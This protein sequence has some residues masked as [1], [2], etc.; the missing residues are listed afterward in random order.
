MADDIL[1]RL[2]VPRRDFQLDVDLTLPGRGTTAVFGASGSGKSTLLRAIAGLE[3]ELAQFGLEIPDRLFFASRARLP[4]LEVI[5]SQH[6][7]VSEN[8][9]AVDLRPGRGPD[10]RGRGQRHECR[11]N[12]GFHTTRIQ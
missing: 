11:E 9:G 12:E 7:D 1:V 3:P 8:P 5:G 6:F 10:C 2:R 4:P